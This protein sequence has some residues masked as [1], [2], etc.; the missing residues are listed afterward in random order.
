MNADEK[1][2]KSYEIQMR[3]KHRCDVEPPVDRPQHA[4]GIAS[5]SHFSPAQDNLAQLGP[6]LAPKI[7]P[8]RPKLLPSWSQSRPMLPL[9][10]MKISIPKKSQ[11]TPT[12]MVV[13][14]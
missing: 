2:I 7:H 8:T 12:T 11:K 9:E 3:F 10:T 6:K 14:I 5:G 1:H 4:S 13:F